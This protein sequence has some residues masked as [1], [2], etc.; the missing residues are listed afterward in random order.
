MGEPWK[1]DVKLVSG[2]RYTWIRN[3]VMSINPDRPHGHVRGGWPAIVHLLSHVCH[4]RMRPR[5]KPH[6]SRQA[7][8]ERQMQQYAI[9]QG[10]HLGKLKRKTKPPPQKY[11]I[12][13]NLVKERYQR[14]L[15][16]EA[17][18]ENKFKRAQ[19][20]LKKAKQERKTYEKRHGS[21]VTGETR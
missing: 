1:G 17:N 13:E 2:N 20:G 7:R 6:D 15:V 4:N 9:D 16:R 21:R 18:W 3:G 11:R 19:N 8:I 14:I 12:E 5:G 10:F